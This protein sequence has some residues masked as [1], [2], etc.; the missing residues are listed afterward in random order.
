MIVLFAMLLCGLL[1]LG[2]LVVDRGVVLLTQ[3]Q[4]QA[5]ADPAALE[6]L[7]VR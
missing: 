5:S 1:A 7:R 2:G 3:E 6:G 4:M